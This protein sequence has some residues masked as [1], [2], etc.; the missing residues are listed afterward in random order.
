MAESG[1]NN[2][3]RRFLLASTSVMGAVGVV[4]ATIPL[5]AYWR[6]SAR[7]RAGGAPVRADISKLAAGQQL[8]L[9]W[10]G[11]PVSVI[12]RSPAMI[13]RTRD[14][15]PAR[16]RD[17]HSRAPQQ[18]GY[19]GGALRAIRPEIGVL[20]GV[21]THLGCSPNFHP[22]P[23]VDEFGRDRSGR[24]RSGRDWPGGYFCPCHGSR[25]DL[26]GRVFRDMP[27][28]LNLVVPPHRYESEQVVVIGEDEAAG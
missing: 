26:A 28:T 9:A 24:D 27:A 12:R 3:R 20:I 4:A 14:L 25:F 15:D 16:L 6:P 8:T 7:A 10:Q 11:R 19:A 22:E 2:G 18:P 1:V 21:C 13:A 23:G 17:P 5:V